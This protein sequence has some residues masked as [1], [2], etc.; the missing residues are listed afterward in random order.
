MPRKKRVVEEVVVGE[1]VVEEVAR[2]GKRQGSG[3]KK[4]PTIDA[5]IVGDDGEI[6]MSPDKVPEPPRYQ[7]NG[8]HGMLTLRDLK[9]ASCGSVLDWSGVA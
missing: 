7:C 4:T 8:C 6:G 3:R 1:V 9:C 2:G 5:T